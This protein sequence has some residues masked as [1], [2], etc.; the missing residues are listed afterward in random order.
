L[1]LL[2]SNYAYRITAIQ[3]QFPKYGHSYFWFWN[4]VH[5]L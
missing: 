2:V 3:S 1:Q 4:A 5:W